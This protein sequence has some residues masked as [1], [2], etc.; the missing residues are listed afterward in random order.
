MFNVRHIPEN[1]FS[2]SPQRHQPHDPLQ[3]DERPL[4]IGWKKRIS[5][6]ID[7]GRVYYTNGRQSQ[8]NFPNHEQN[9]NS[10]IT[11]PEPRAH[12]QRAEAEYQARNELAQAEERQ[13]L[14]ERRALIQRAEAE[15]QAHIELAQ[16]EER[17]NLR[18]HL[19]LID[20]NNNFNLYNIALLNSLKQFILQHNIQPMNPQSVRNYISDL[21]HLI[22]MLNDPGIEVDLKRL[23][24]KIFEEMY[25]K[26]AG[27][28]KL[29][30][31]GLTM[32][33]ARDRQ[34]L[35]QQLNQLNSIYNSFMNSIN[36]IT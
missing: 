6:N 15:Y 30:D 18:E 26:L 21:I 11:E 19:E 12:I 4:P 5:N 27:E 2:R 14:I 3:N 28:K 1:R 24:K 13:A 7:P 35:I 10:V 9:P 36:N 31:D 29:I 23:C 22:R 32:H 17:L 25:E 34:N 20:L 8:W 16:A 33:D